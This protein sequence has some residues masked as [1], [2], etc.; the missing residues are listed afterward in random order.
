MLVLILFFYIKKYYGEVETVTVH[1]KTFLVRKLPDSKQAAEFLYQLSDDCSKLVKH[2]LAKYPDSEDV[3]R[4][5]ANYSPKDMSE[6]SPESGYTSYS[7]NKSTIVLCLRQ[8]EDNKFANKNVV[9]YVL[10]HELAHLM[11][12]SIGHTKEFWDNFKLLLREAIDIGVYE[13]IDF[14]TNPMPYCGIKITSSVI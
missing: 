2:M 8:K 14:N 13:K 11:T 5:Y 6:G 4:L 10:Y 12:E 3:H 1:G 7:L 9:R